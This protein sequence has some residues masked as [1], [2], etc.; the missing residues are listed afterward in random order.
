M[1]MVAVEAAAL[2]PVWPFQFTPLLLERVALQSL[3][4]ASLLRTS[5]PRCRPAPRRRECARCTFGSKLIVVSM[6]RKRSMGVAGV[7]VSVQVEAAAS[8]GPEASATAK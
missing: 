2:A 5:A 8:S 3:R 1:S 4:A 6:L 7:S